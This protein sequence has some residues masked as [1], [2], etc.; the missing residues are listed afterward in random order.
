MASS[1]TLP[2]RIAIVPFT[3]RIKKKG[4]RNR[5][6][7]DMNEKPVHLLT[8]RYAIRPAISTV[9]SQSGRQPIAFQNEYITNGDRK[10]PS[11]TPAVDRLSPKLNDTNHHTNP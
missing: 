2:H 5:A 4:K 9:L 6:R 11:N 1:M 3:T 7:A 10:A 8:P